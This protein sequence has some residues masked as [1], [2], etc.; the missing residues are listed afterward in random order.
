VTI[1]NVWCEGGRALVAVDTAS[2]ENGK[3]G[4]ELS[5]L[6]PIVHLNAVAACRGNAAFFL[7]L[8]HGLLT[9]SILGDFDALVR[10]TPRIT[11]EAFDMF[12][13]SGGSTQGP[14]AHATREHQCVV[15]AG[16]SPTAQRMR[17]FEFRC[18]QAQGAFVQREFDRGYRSPWIQEF[19][20]QYPILNTVEA[21][22]RLARAQLLLYEDKA[23]EW[24]TGGR[25]IV[26][27]MDRLSTTIKTVCHFD[28][29]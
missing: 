16:W 18:N 6:V 1:L 19:D 2:T 21:M 20:R 5:K 13:A 4:R 27:E 7:L 15:L 11:Q 24:R 29:E 22:E 9:R 23:P 14:D 8:G 12:M 25:L 10:A 17:A 26:A 28:G 3:R